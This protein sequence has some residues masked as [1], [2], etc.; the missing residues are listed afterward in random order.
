MADWIEYFTRANGDIFYFDNTRIQKNGNLVSVWNRVRYKTS[1][2]AASS[3]QSYMKIDCTD[4]SKITMQS[5]F[6][7]D[8]DWI[9][10]AMATNNEETPKE[11][12]DKNSVSRQLADILCKG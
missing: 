9:T 4:Y 1:V 6:Y 2:M 3:Y 8:K 10:P 7:I 12:I 11:P 5:T